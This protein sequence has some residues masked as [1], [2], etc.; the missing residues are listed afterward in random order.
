M[1]LKIK[2]ESEKKVIDDEKEEF[3][4]DE[5]NLLDSFIYGSK[6]TELKQQYDKLFSH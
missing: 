6:W 5:S 4:Y 3:D 2:E 1:N